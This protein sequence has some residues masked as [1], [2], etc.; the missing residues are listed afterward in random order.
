MKLIFY[1]LILLLIIIEVS[2]QYLFKLSYLTK[3]YLT[4]SYLTKS[5]L[6]NKYN[7]VNTKVNYYFIIGFILY[8]ISG[9]FVYKVLEYGD[10]G[11]INVIWHLLHFFSL[12]FV[13]YY[14]LGEKLT[15]KQII[16]SIFGIISLFLLMGESHHH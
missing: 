5:N 16:G 10:L 4:K 7:K 2:A 13:S 1:F 6:T 3:S 8:S 11:V 15:N 12:F 14:F 9:F